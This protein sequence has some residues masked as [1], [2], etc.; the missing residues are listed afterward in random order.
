VLVESV[1]SN[2]GFRATPVVPHQG[3]GRH[4]KT[5]RSGRR[6]PRLDPR[7]SLSDIIAAPA[8]VALLLA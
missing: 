6:R 1:L 7:T 3:G 2:L 4:A 5:P 8:V